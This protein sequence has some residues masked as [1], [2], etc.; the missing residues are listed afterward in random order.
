MSFFIY[1]VFCLLVFFPKKTHTFRRGGKM[2]AIQLEFTIDEES[3]T[4]NKIKYMQKRIDV[5]EESFGK[6]RRKLFAEMME[7][8]KENFNLKQKIE[9]LIYEKNKWVYGQEDCLF[10]VQKT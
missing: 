5:I 10:D 8:K 1:L 3:E 9:G 4:E 6:V 2:N 7:I